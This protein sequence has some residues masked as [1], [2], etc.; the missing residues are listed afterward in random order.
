[1]KKVLALI[2]SIC[3]VLCL[4][5]CSKTEPTNSTQSTTTITFT[6]DQ[7]RAIVQEEITKLNIPS[8]DKNEFTEDQIRKI[9]QEEITKLNIPSAD[10]S[11]FTED[12]IR[13][14]VQDAIAKLKTPSADKNEFKAGEKLFCPV[15][16]SFKLPIN[17]QENKFA[18]I[19]SLVVTKKKE[20]NIENLD[21]FW[22]D[23]NYKYFAR[24]LYEVKIS[25]TVDEEFAGKKIYINLQFEHYNDFFG[26]IGGG[27]AIINPD[28]SFTFDYIAHSNTNENVIIPHSAYIPQF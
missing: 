6:E 4:V 13:A 2:L 21:E 9:I 17:G 14:I 7:I 8:A 11:E 23:G 20:A 1:M 25:G 27:T 18:T 28:G 24:Y 10:E 22:G 5:A 19:T 15:G 3:F 16:N 26:S 12:Q